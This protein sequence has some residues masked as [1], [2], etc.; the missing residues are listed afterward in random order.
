MK[1]ERCSYNICLCFWYQ[2]YQLMEIMKIQ[3]TAPRIVLYD[4]TDVLQESV[5]SEII[6]NIGLSG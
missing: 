4:F 6:D 1:C 2:T 3:A 5:F